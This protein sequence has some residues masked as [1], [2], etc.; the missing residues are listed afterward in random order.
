VQLALSECEHLKCNQMNRQTATLQ[1]LLLWQESIDKP[2]LERRTV[3]LRSPSGGTLSVIPCSTP[4]SAFPV[5]WS[6]LKSVNVA[7]YH[8]VARDLS[9]IIDRFSSLQIPRRVLRD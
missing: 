6:R 8:A 1:Q 4:R 9:S 3:A 7:V 5:A 2:I